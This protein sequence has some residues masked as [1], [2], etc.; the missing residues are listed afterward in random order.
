MKR[1]YGALGLI[2]GLVAIGFGIAAAGNYSAQG[3]EAEPRSDASHSES[4]TEQSAATYQQAE[5]QAPEQEAVQ[6]VLQELVPRLEEDPAFAGVW[7]EP[8]LDWTIHIAT[9]SPADSIASILDPF[10]DVGVRLQVHTVSYSKKE[11]S[12]LHY[13]IADAAEAWSTRGVEIVSVGFNAKLNRVRLRIEPADEATVAALTREYGDRVVIEQS[14]PFQ[15]SACTS[16]SNCGSPMKGG[17][18]INSQSGNGCTSGFV[19]RDIAWAGAAYMMLAGH[20]I[21]NGGGIGPSWLH[22]ASTFGTANSNQ[23]ATG[24]S[25]DSGYIWMS[26]LASPGN[27]LF[28]ST[29]D[30]RSMTGF[31]PNVSQT[32]GTWVCKSRENH[33]L[34]MRPDP[35]RRCYCPT[36]GGCGVTPPVDSEL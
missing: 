12:E 6:A 17:L 13:Q 20:C 29:S 25:T 31:I 7:V 27:Q 32:I 36:S 26:S 19:T 3:E 28:V 30:I 4:A 22:N 10:Q 5:A 23:Y 33:E 34:H 16:R 35:R 24:S 9:T 1:I 18:S 15:V 11:L 2:T 8:E 14:P 21:T